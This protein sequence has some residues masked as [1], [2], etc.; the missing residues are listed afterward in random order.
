VYKKDRDIRTGPVQD[1]P[2]PLK[3]DSKVSL[4][5]YFTAI[6]LHWKCRPD[7]LL[8]CARK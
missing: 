1:R 8:I 5:C 4:S 2:Y 3:S 6:G 7:K